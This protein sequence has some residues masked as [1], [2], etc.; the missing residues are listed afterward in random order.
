MN[1]VAT[2]PVQYT[3]SNSIQ[4]TQAK[5]ANSLEQMDTQKKANTYAELGLD[6]TRV[7]SARSMLA[8]QQAQDTVSSQVGT[9][10]D[11]YDTSLNA[12]DDDMSKLRQQMLDVVGSGDS[13]GLQT[14]I[15]QAF[16]SMRA[17]LNTTVAGNPIFAGSMT[18]TT[19]FKPT[20]LD[21]LISGAYPTDAD[22]FTNDQ[23][24]LTAQVSNDITMQYGQVASD[25][26]TKLVAAFR[27]LAA[28]GPFTD[29]V[30]DTQ[31]QAIQTAM[32]QITDGLG[33]VRTANANNGR[34]QAQIDTVTARG[35][36]RT[37]MLKTVIGNAEDA[38]LGQV[39]L[40][41]TN[42][43]TM[44]NASYSVFAK[45]SSLSLANYLM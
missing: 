23:V 1:R 35:E 18:G 32:D 3:M 14:T 26:A 22:A 40:D 31:M 10:L 12:I 6:T 39:A 33:D 44:L 21:D 34:L 38:D 5:L 19:P 13:Y 9:T 41:I 16:A 4:N 28:A 25:V 11:Y 24:K 42:S 45:I 43:Q 2:L 20:S 8:R 30:T 29:K 36:D 27:T 7:L 15:E 17:A 37:T